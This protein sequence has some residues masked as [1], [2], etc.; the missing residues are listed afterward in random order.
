MFDPLYKGHPKQD[1]PD[2]AYEIASRVVNRFD[3][4]DWEDIEKNDYWL[5]QVILAEIDK[6]AAEERDWEKEPWTES[7]LQ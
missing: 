5:W 6:V 7:P 3:F 2:L 4:V 1:Y